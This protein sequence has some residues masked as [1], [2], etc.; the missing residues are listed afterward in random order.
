MQPG[1]LR[2]FKPDARFPLAAH[3]TFAGLP[4]VILSVFGHHPGRTAGRVEVL[5]DGKV[6]GPWGYPW[7]EQNSEV[8]DAAR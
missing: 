7:V 4:F 6:L 5:I 1:D 3:E 2:R 8:L